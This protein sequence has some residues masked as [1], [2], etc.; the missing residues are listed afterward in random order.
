MI[1]IIFFVSIALIA[2]ML[3]MYTR[4]I[5]IRSAGP[6]D[7]CLGLAMM[8]SI[9]VVVLIGEQVKY[10]LGEHIWTLDKETIF[11]SLKP[12]WASVWVYTLSLSFL[13]ISLL[14]QYLRIFPMQKFRVICWTV[15][16]MVAL[17]GLWS[18]FGS[19]FICYPVAYFWDNSIKGG[20][21]LNRYGVWF[22]TAGLNILT[23]FALIILP[24][25]VLQ[26]MALPK[27]Q[28]RALM[29]VFA[30]GGFGCIVSILRLHYLVAISKSKDPTWDNPAPATWSSI[31]SSVGITCASL[32]ALKPLLSRF[33]PRHFNN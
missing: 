32:T 18:L 15:L 4:F 31:E 20:K 28:K 23:D 17:S 10:G 3:R 12:F 16:G 22:S 26:S 7:F 21:C 8:F 6:E 30:L 13:K 19:V 14:L 11:K 24:M 1:V 33:F 2:F 25:P 27:K 5:M 9:G 29:F